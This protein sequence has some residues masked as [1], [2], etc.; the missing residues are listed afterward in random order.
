MADGKLFVSSV[1]AHTVYA[2]EAGSG[3]QLWS[4]TAGGRVDSPP[5]IWQGRVLFGSADGHVYQLRAGDGA[6]VWRFRA[7]PRTSG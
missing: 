3:K 5:T 4:F 7:A 1:N 2:L 6:L